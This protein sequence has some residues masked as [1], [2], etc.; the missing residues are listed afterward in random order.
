MGVFP[1]GTVVQLSNDMV[2]LVISVNAS[3]LLYPNVLIYDPSVP[4]S[5]APIIDLADRDLKIVN[6]I[7]P[8][9]LP[10]KV[11]DYLNPRSRISYF[12]DSEE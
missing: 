10:D 5:Q 2:G 9:K 4:R 3:S 7:L 6:A 8:N 12:F 1:P 11:R